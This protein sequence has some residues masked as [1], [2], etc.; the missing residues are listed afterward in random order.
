ML[1]ESV[2]LLDHPLD[3]EPGQEDAGSFGRA[4]LGDR[5]VHSRRHLRQPGDVV[6]HVPGTPDWM[7]LRQRV[8]EI[9]LEAV[10]LIEDVAVPGKLRERHHVLEAPPDDGGRCGLPRH[11]GFRIKAPE[12]LEALPGLR[13]PRRQRLAAEGPQSHSP[14]IASCRS[15]A[16]CPA[17]MKY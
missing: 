17:P 13:R 4:R 1:Q 3:D 10:E 14:I 16:S 5:L 9:E 12:R 7:R 8:D 15:K 11:Q 2:E 6:L